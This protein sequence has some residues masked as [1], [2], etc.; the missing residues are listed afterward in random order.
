MDST[1]LGIWLSIGG[2][3]VSGGAYFVTKTDIFGRMSKYKADKAKK[4]R[5]KINNDIQAWVIRYYFENGEGENLVTLS[6]GKKIPYLAKKT[7]YG[8]KLRRNKVVFNPQDI[9]TK[10]KID[11]KI[12]EARKL[13]GQNIW[14]GKILSLSG[15]IE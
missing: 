3:V 10:Q 7:W 13:I 9:F 4:R 11:N 14:N 15:M 6:N 8:S 2:I 12:I 5:S 1:I